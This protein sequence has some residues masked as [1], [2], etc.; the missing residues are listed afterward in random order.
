MTAPPT[1]ATR[2]AIADP[3]ALSAADTLSQLDAT[4]H[5]LDNDEVTRRQQ[6]YGINRLPRLE[7]PTL[8]RIALRQFESPLIYVLFL[9]AAVSLFLGE[10]TDAGFIFLVLLI[11]AVI[12]TWQEYTAQRSAEALSKLVAVRARVYRDGDTRVVD[13][14]DL[15]PGDIVLLE[16]GVKVPADLRLL[17]SH[18]LECDES[19]LTGEVLPV[20]KRPEDILARGCPLGDRFNLAFGGTI[21]THGRA[22]GVVVATGLATAL[23]EIASTVLGGESSKPPLLVRMERFTTRIALFIGVAVLLMAAVALWRGM[24]WHEIFF[25][26]VALAVSA[27]P[28]GLPVAMT[29]ALAVGTERMVRRSVIVRRLV[30]VESLGSCTYIA[31]DKTGT[32]TVNQMTLRQLRFPNQGPTTVTGEGLVPDGLILPPEDADADAHERHIGR[33][34]LAGALANEAFYGQRED[35][36][37]FSGD[38]VDAALLVF[39]HKARIHQPDIRE[40]Y[41][42]IATIPFEP[43]NRFSASLNSVDGR[44]LVSVKGAV[45]TVLDMCDRMVADDGDVALVSEEI[46]AQADS[47]AHEGYRVLALAAGVV[48]DA[49]AESFT[50]QQLQGLSFLGIVG[51]IDPLRPEVEDAMVACRRAGIQVAM[52]TGD[53]PVTALSIARDL[54]MADDM[55]QVVTGAQLT[56]AV[57]SGGDAALD[58]MTR[59]ARVFARVE[60]RQK[61]EVVQSLGRN[62]HYV[63]VTGDGANDAPALQYAHVGVA[64]GRGGTDVAREASDIILANDNFA[65][66]VAGIEE[67]RIAYANVRKVIFLLISTGAAEIV[68]F[69]LALAAGLPLPLGAVQLLWLNLVTN[70]I[71]DVAL[72]FEPAEGGEMNRAPRSPREGIF[73]RLMLERVALSAIVIGVIA[74]S[75]FWWLLEKGYSESEARNLCLLLMVLFENIQAF[76]SRSET[77]SVFHHNPLR[78][79]LLLV[80]AIVAQLIHVG[81]MFTPGLQDVLGVSP[82]NFETWSQLLL[83]SLFLLVVMELHKLL[84]RRR[85]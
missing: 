52:I 53:H 48:E 74:F 36:W 55:E 19:L 34:A 73:N 58:R 51:M 70:G 15:V 64:M 43:E 9:A 31:T 39:A 10:F 21:V 41:P 40:R 13:A 45:E 22:R 46:L 69:A 60:P 33:L 82:V 23:G 12:G 35:E 56:E 49:G 57:A 28:E 37:V 75:L 38:A 72:A 44:R 24:V 50:P 42:E 7:P 16:S 20:R 25:L 11:N 66:V 3:Y 26:A 14:E 1:P 29:V 71:Q 47:M 5:G 8:L 76:N 18:G 68:L 83:L 78:N 4:M 84:Q 65:S 54:E 67:G 32:L 81:A 85:S 30:A 17:D 62:G 61:L 27:I 2:S 63:A 80:G 79:R 59:A 77:L 6:D